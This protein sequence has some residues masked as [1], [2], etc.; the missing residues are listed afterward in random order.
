MSPTRYHSLCQNDTALLCFR[1]N[2]YL[3][4]CVNNHTRVECFIYDQQLDRCS[5]CLH[6][7]RCLRGDPTRS[8]D[9]VCLCPLCYSG[10]QCQFS[11]K[12]F[13]FTLD[14]L[15]YTDLVLSHRSRTVVILLIFFSAL[16]F[17][18]AIPNNL[19]SF[20]TFHQKSC[21]RNGVGHYLLTLSVISQFN[22]ALLVVRLTHLSM[23]VVHQSSSPTINTILCKVLNYSLVS[24]SR[25]VY[26]LSSLIAIERV[27]MT[28]VLN[29]QWL[30]HPRIA[31]RLILITLLTTLLSTAYEYLFFRS[32]SISDPTERSMCIFE[33]PHMYRSQWM[34]VHLLV[35]TLHSVVPFIVN[36]CST[37]TIGIMVVKKKMN[38]RRT[39][40]SQRMNFVERIR[41]IL[42]VLNENRELVIGPGLT[43]IPQL[44]SLPLFISSFTLDCQNIENSWI[45][46]L[47][48]ISYWTSFTPQMISFFLYISPSS[49]YSDEWRKTKLRQQITSLLQRRQSE[50][51]PLPPSTLVSRTTQMNRT[52]H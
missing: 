30:K 47:L 35:S 23:K 10:G 7:G 28:L 1:D 4:V 14:Q 52:A 19:F 17:V 2:H 33:F 44:F 49:F 13:S 15:F 12:S 25:M 38:T 24:S 22:L 48:I 32:L 20:V 8:T 11:S 39:Q 6:N 34:I 42:N 40:K 18:L 50:R 36:L 16:G 51:A 27:Y 37:I 31:R 3:C 43:L 29:G 26:W 9:F 45:R 46:Y 21:L 5:K 41:F